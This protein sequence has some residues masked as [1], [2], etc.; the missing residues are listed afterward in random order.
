MAEGIVLFCFIGNCD[1]RMDAWG[2]VPFLLDVPD[3]SRVSFVA[4]I[5]IPDPSAAG[6]KYPWKAENPGSA[7]SS[8]YDG[9][10]AHKKPAGSASCAA[11]DSRVLIFPFPDVPFS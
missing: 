8:C 3:S 6:T 1:F 9:D 11:S 7:K 4:G 10:K 5:L 2:F